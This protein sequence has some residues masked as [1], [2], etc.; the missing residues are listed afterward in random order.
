MA[1]S[2]RETPDSAARVVYRY[3]GRGEGYPDIPARDLAVVEVEALDP[4]AWAAAL[5]LGLYTLEQVEQV[6]EVD[7]AGS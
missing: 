2:N 6:T 7:H 3:V 5:A 1:T 4:A